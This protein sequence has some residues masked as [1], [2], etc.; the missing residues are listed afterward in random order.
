MDMR[1]LVAFPP[2]GMKPKIDRNP[3]GAF[4]STEIR[5]STYTSVRRTS[6]QEDAPRKIPP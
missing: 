1:Q 2:P 3:E 5:Q 4:A 6:C